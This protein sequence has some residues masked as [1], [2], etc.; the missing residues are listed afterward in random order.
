MTQFA[1]NALIQTTR[2]LGAGVGAL[3]AFWRGMRVQILVAIGSWGFGICGCGGVTAAN[4]PYDGGSKS[5]AGQASVEGGKAC[6][7]DMQC[8]PGEICAY[9][10]TAGC[11]ARGECVTN[12][13]PLSG[14]GCIESMGCGCD[15]GD[16]NYNVACAPGVSGYVSI[17]VLHLG[18]CAADGG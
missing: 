3:R 2:K 16:I 14:V 9:L 12:F 4:L 17:P 8:G 18:A 10:E 13:A 1:W 15:G 6:S 5:E 7:D 11:A